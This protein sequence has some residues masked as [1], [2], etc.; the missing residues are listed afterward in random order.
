MSLLWALLAA[1]L[2]LV[3]AA[4][5]MGGWFSRPAAPTC[6]RIT[7][8]HID[9]SGLRACTKQNPEGVPVPASYLTQEHL[10]SEQLE[11]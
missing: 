1:V 5:Y 9:H 2:L 7:G 11:D 4:A 6:P 3:A 8:Y 10:C